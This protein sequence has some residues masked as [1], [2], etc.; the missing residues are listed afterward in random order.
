MFRKYQSI[1]R[2][3]SDSTEMMA[4][5]WMNSRP[6]ASMISC[7]IPALRYSSTVLWLT[8]AARGWMA[9]PRCRS[10]TSD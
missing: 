5:F 7:S 1:S 8:S 9:V 10:T 2:P 3:P 6:E 4:P